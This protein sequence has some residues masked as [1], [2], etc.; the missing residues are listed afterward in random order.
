MAKAVARQAW[1]GNSIVYSSLLWV[2]SALLH[3][4]HAM[5]AGLST[6]LLPQIIAAAIIP[7]IVLL[8]ASAWL[9]DVFKPTTDVSNEYNR[10]VRVMSVK[11]QSLF[12][13]LVFDVKRNR[14]KTY[15]PEV[16]NVVIPLLSLRPIMNVGAMI[17]FA[18]FFLNGLVFM[19]GVLVATKL[20]LI[21]FI[22]AWV[23]SVCLNL[24]VISRVRNVWREDKVK[25]ATMKHSGNELMSMMGKAEFL[26]FKESD[27]VRRKLDSLIS[28][29]VSSTH[30]I[31]HLIVSGVLD[32][33]TVKS[34][35][36]VLEH[37]LN[38]FIPESIRQTKAF[39]KKYKNAQRSARTIYKRDVLPSFE[40]EAISLNAKV[41]DIHAMCKKIEANQEALRLEQEELAIT[42]DFNINKLVQNKIIPPPAFPEFNELHFDSIE[43]KVA[44]KRIVTNSLPALL[45]AKEQTMD[46]QLIDRIDRQLEKTKTFIKSLA[47]GT[48]ESIERNNRLDRARR[49]SVLHLDNKE[50][51]MD[52]I[53]HLLSVEERY[54]ATYDETL[55][56]TLN[57]R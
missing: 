40:G 57:K 34:E 3:I 17:I 2:M 42:A 55:P 12:S 45:K 29:A 21:S 51:S 22:M 43:K 19:G 56:P 32:A 18:G 26:T 7:A 8:V 46:D 10:R 54:I 25:I 49:E 14:T 9:E 27:H 47:L 4:G 13:M 36:E 38:T 53:D 39:F 6:V 23:I 11:D 5:I 52:S 37:T 16:Q 20:T 28:A 50:A 41:N 31:N 44:A 48:A 1:V 24:N 30:K 33:D 35:I 15:Y